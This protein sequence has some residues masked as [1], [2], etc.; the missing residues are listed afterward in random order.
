VRQRTGGRLAA[1]LAC[2]CTGLCVVIGLLA[3]GSFVLA[4]DTSLTFRQ[5]EPQGTTDEP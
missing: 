3:L 5:S 1:V 4:V 2:S